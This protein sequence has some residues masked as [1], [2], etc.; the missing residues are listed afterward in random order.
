MKKGAVAPFSREERM[1]RVWYMTEHGVPFEMEATAETHNRV[2]IMVYAGDERGTK[3]ACKRH[4]P[5][6]VRRVCVE[7][8]ER[9][10]RVL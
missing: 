1:R 5:A 4:R 10:T 2:F 7:D 3:K 9:I 6:K 8:E